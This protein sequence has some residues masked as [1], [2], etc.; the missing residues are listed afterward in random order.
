MLRRNPNVVSLTSYI[1]VG[2]NNMTVNQGQMLINLTPKD[3]RS[4]GLTTVMDELL[5]AARTVPGI[6]LSLQPVQDLTISSITGRA[7][8]QFILGAASRAILTPWVPR[9]LAA[10]RRSADLAHVS[11]SFTEQGRTIQIDVDHSTA[12]RFGITD[13]TIDNAL[14]DA[15]GQRIIS[16]IYTQSNDY[17]VILTA[18]PAL[19]DTVGALNTFYIP[20]SGGG[21]VPLGSIAHIS[22]R[23]APLTLDHLGQFPAAMFSFDTAPG[24]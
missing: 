3:E 4:A 13:A 15:F 19:A 22:V 2:S 18:N 17:R 6:Q 7:R 1:G 9:L 24:A 8:Y 5:R 10:L 20:S 12:A 21:Q 16:T 11:S 14:Y 23:D